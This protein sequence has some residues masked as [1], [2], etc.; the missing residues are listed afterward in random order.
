MYFNA[1]G[2]SV[3]GG[4]SGKDTGVGCHFLLQGTFP[5]QGL[6]PYFLHGRQILSTEP[7]GKEAMEYKSSTRCLGKRPLGFHL[8]SL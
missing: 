4:F 7:P 5:D 1:T 6:N 8:A 2:S 3:H